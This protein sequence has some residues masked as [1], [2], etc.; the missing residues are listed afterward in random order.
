MHPVRRLPVS[1]FLYYAP[2]DKRGLISSFT[3][4]LLLF[5]VPFVGGQGRS[6]LDDQFPP[7]FDY[8]YT[9]KRFLR[10]WS[11]SRLCPDIL[12]LSLC[13][14]LSMAVRGHVIWN[15]H[16]FRSFFVLFLHL[17]LV[18]RDDVVR[19]STKLS[20]RGRTSFLR[21]PFLKALPLS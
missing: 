8:T 6:A 20:R 14:K 16:V 2:S 7:C 21:S 3:Q 18:Q 13:C 11:Y 19:D 4:H 17:H 9:L 12:S 1:P 5:S 15:A 10:S